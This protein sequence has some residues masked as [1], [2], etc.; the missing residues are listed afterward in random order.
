MEKLSSPAGHREGHA[1]GDPVR[2]LPSPLADSPGDE[3]NPAQGV[4]HPAPALQDDGEDAV[5]DV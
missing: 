5:E 1:G 3:S 2:P 4:A